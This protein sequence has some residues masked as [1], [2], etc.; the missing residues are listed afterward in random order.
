VGQ[1]GHL[2]CTSSCSLWTKADIGPQSNSTGR[3]AFSRISLAHSSTSE[4]YSAGGT[5]VAVSSTT[6]SGAD[7]LLATNDKT[8][9]SY[10]SAEIIRVSVPLRGCG[11]PVEWE[12][13]WQ[14][15]CVGPGCRHAVATRL[16]TRQRGGD[17]RGTCGHALLHCMSPLLGVKR[18]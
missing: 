9:R 6:A 16:C 15:S 3:A 8:L 11:E 4:R 10:Y 17:R 1:S 5:P 18:T 12:V 7:A 14:F 2:Q 13:E